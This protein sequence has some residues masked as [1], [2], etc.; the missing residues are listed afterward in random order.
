[1]KLKKKEQEIKRKAEIEHRKH[2]EEEAKK[3]ETRRRS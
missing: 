2:L 1:M 3:K